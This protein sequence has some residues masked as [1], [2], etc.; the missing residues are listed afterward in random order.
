MLKIPFDALKE[1]LDFLSSELGELILSYVS[2][3][4]ISCEFC[5]VASEKDHPCWPCCPICGYAY[6]Y[7]EIQALHVMMAQEGD[8]EGDQEGDGNLQRDDD[9]RH[10]EKNGDEIP[11]GNIPD[12]DKFGSCKYCSEDDQRILTSTCEDETVCY[13]CYDR[14]R[15]NCCQSNSTWEEILAWRKR[16]L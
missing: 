3:Q 2:V 1:A 7:A 14:Y 13:N 10:T 5:Q 8:K 12:G 9:P 6:S 11:D 4:E 16:G 15:C